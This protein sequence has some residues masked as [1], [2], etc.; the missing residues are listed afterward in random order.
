MCPRDWEGMRLRTTSI[1]WFRVTVTLLALIGAMLLLCGQAIA[2]EGGPEDN[3]PMIGDGTVTPSNLS[4]EGG[5][6]QLS[7]EVTDDF[8]VSMVY[9]E[10]Y[11]PDGST[12]LIQLYEGGPNTYYGT[13]EVPGNGSN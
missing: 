8:G 5:S 13:L 9:A 3:P 1:G 4:H 10:I 6:V 7:A 12:Q 2:E 11:D